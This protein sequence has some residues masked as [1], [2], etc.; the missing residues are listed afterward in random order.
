MIIQKEDVRK[1]G[2]HHYQLICKICIELLVQLMQNSKLLNPFS[3]H[4]KPVKTT[5]TYIHTYVYVCI[6]G[7]YNGKV[8]LI[9]SMNSLKEKSVM[10]SW[11]PF[12]K[13]QTNGF[14]FPFKYKNGN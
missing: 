2:L 9:K 1:F 6:I 5:H 8:A 11:N 10:A 7:V 14:T 13:N 4:C 3:W 12:L